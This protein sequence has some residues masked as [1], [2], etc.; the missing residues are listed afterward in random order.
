MRTPHSQDGAGLTRLAG[1]AGWTLLAGLL[2]SALAS[3]AGAAVPDAY[4]QMWDGVAGQIDEGIERHRKG[5]AVIEV[6]DADGQPVAG[7]ALEIRQKTHDFLFGC[8]LFALGQLESPELNRKYEE[9]FARINNFATLP[10]YWREL[11]PEDGRPRFAEGSPPIW[12]R[13]PPDQLVKWCRARGITAKGHALMYAKTMFMPDWI[14]PDDPQRLK[15]LA[16]RH[17]SQIA[18]RYGRD[19]AVWDV[20][21]EELPRLAHPQQWHAVPDDYL[22]WC[23]QEAGRLFPKNATLMINDGINQSH[24]TTDQYEKLVRGLLQRQVRVEGI[25]IQFHTSRG[26]MLSGKVYAPSHMLAVYEQ[27]GRLGL[28]LYI[29]EITVP[30]VG[31]NGPAEQATIVA[32]LYRL[33]FSTPA[34]AG[35]TWWN[36]A[37]GT[38]YRNENAALGG[39]LDKDMNPKPAYQALDQ[40]INHQWKTNL[41]V[42]TDAQGRAQFRGFYGGYKAQVTLRNRVQDFEVH[43]A[44]GA[45]ATY[46][47][48]LKKH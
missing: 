24:V 10:F 44:K 15:T 41:T 26:A 3:S 1:C 4:Q 19:I 28:P 9:A 5:D 14:K 47:L 34:M 45:S 46:R 36:L 17:M 42:K 21:N 7:A 39:L 8:N 6:V 30:G 13:P 11:E 18:E 43:V 37:D 23:F 32:N 35:V 29:T 20:V 12:R 25:G 31:E 16:Q 22:A 48:V 2:V 40:L 27:L 38:A 33:W